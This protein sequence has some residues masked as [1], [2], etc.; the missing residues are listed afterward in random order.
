[1]AKHHFGLALLLSFGIVLPAWAGRIVDQALAVSFTP[2]PYFQATKEA[3]GKP[4][5]YTLTP[6]DHTVTIRTGAQVDRKL[7]SAAP[8]SPTEAK[9]LCVSANALV[10]KELTLKVSKRFVLDSQNGVECQFATANGRTVHWIGAP[11]PAQLVFFS[12]DW[13]KVP[14]KEQVS[15][16]RRFIGGVQIF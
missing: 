14:T 15:A 6:P 2:P 11:V 7:G 13:P 12:A 4:V 5:H 16:F 3:E 1:M 8:F 10:G 9:A